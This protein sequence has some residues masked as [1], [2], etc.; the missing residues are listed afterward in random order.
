M[1]GDVFEDP[2]E[3]AV[4]IGCNPQLGAIG[5]DS[6]QAVEQLARDD[7][8]LV[9]APFG[10]R[11]RKQY[12]DA[13]DRASRQSRHQQPRVVGKDAN[14]IEPLPLDLR[15]QLDDPVFENLAADEAD[16][17][18]PFGLPCEMLASAE[19]NLEP[20]G[21]SQSAKQRA[22]VKPTGPRNCDRKPRQQS[23]EKGLLPRAQRPGTAPA[24]Q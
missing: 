11:I 20:N 6:R 17:R 7:A 16:F 12:E 18:M 15:K 10:P 19:T 8:P 14:I 21:A 9:V 22:R 1:I 3:I 13:V 24:E 2:A 5:H 23:G 4:I